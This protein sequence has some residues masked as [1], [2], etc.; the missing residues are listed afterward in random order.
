M[1]TLAARMA[2]QRAIFHVQRE[3]EDLVLADGRWALGL[4]D[5]GSLDGLAYWPETEARFWE[6]VGSGRATELN[7]YQAVI[8][9]RTPTEAMGYNHQNELRIESPEEAH[10]I[11]LR[12]EKIWSEHPRYFQVSSTDRFLEKAQ[13]T[14][15]LIGDQI[16]VCCHPA[17]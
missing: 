7:R 3:M 15:Q 9:L 4:C 2:A 17:S 12:I 1:N 10:Q 13:T 5:R 8:H 11:D 14:L 6:Q 16:P